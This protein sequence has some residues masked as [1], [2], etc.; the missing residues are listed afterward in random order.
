ME[1]LTVSA[2]VNKR[3]LADIN[4][5][6][7]YLRVFFLSYIVNTQGDTIEEWAI[8][9]ERSNA[10]RST[11]HVAL[12]RPTKTSKKHVEQMEGRSESGL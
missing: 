6:R 9:S 7:V 1:D 4:R 10:R 12:A 3:D 2:L 5:C 8:T 11:C